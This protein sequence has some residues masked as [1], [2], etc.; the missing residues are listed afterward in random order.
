MNRIN[1]SFYDETYEKIEARMKSNSVKSIAHC[2]R[3]LVDIGLKIEEA[4]QKN[5]QNQQEDQSEKLMEMLKNNLIWMLE[6]RL[7]TRYMVEKL[8]EKNGDNSRDILDSYKDKSISYVN[9]MLKE[10]VK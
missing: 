9:G 8:P 7:L 6:T 2:V 3:E 1:V 10:K 4:A 5:S